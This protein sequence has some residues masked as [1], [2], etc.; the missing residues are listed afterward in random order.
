[1][2]VGDPLGE[3]THPVENALIG[4][5]EEMRAVPVNEYAFGPDLVEGVARDMGPLV[6]DQNAM[7]GL[8]KHTGVNRSGKPRTDD[9]RF[10]SSEIHYIPNSKNRPM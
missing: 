9:Q 7:P 1:M 4:G 10:T 5:V 3:P 2:L 8:S 6:D